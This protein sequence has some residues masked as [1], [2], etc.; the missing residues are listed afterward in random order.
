MPSLFDLPRRDRRELGEAL[1][2]AI[3]ASKRVDLGPVYTQSLAVANYLRGAR[4]FDIMDPFQPDYVLLAVDV[5]RNQPIWEQV[6]GD[7]ALELG[8]QLRMD[9]RPSPSN[10]DTTIRSL[11][12]AAVAR[13]IMSYYFPERR[14]S[15]AHRAFQKYAVEDGCSGLAVSPTWYPGS[16]WGLKLDAIPAEELIFLPSGSR[17]WDKVNCVVW[18][19][20]VTLNWLRAMAAKMKEA[21]DHS[22]SGLPRK[23]SPRYDDLNVV[24]V[25]PG[26]GITESIR[27]DYA[28]DLSGIMNSRTGDL[29]T[30]SDVSD[31]P[32]M[33]PFVEF[34]QCYVTP[35]KA[36]AE[37]IV[38]MAGEFVFLDEEYAEHEMPQIPIGVGRYAD[39]GG[40]YGRSYAYPKIMASILGERFLLSV[41]RNAGAIDAYGM[42]LASTGMGLQHD[43]IERPSDGDFRI[44]EFTPDAGNPTG[45]PIQLTPVALNQIYGTLPQFMLGASQAVFPTSPILRG[46]T[47][48]REDSDVAL[49]RLD[50]LSN[51]Q[52]AAGAITRAT[53]WSQVYAASLEMIR[54]HHRKGDSI[55][56]TYVD[57]S[58]AG[59]LLDTQEIPRSM[60]EI[61]QEEERQAHEAEQFTA[62]GLDPAMGRALQSAGI[63]QGGPQPADRGP[64]R[65]VPMGQFT[66]GP[67]VIPHPDRVSIGVASVMPRDKVAELV[68]LKESRNE[69]LISAMELQ[70]EVYK[71]GLEAPVGGKAVWNAYELAV[72]N[73][74]SAYGNGIEAGPIIVPVAGITQRIGWWVVRT[75]MD[76]ITFA[77]ASET[78]KRKII[79]LLQ[80]YSPV[81]TPQ[82]QPTVDEIAAMEGMRQQA[83]T[84]GMGPQGAPQPGQMALAQSP[85]A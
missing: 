43:Q 5:P 17:S 77:V 48:G 7:V 13:G 36:H 67:N 14:I 34:S 49:Q 80:A 63:L 29:P 59:I 39:V 69:G 24:E 41:A 55:P 82:S 11:R 85:A 84:Q 16:G 8:R 71:R 56:L 52:I 26:H 1:R 23:G 57:D 33:V 58:M 10:E 20:W 73:L 68:G 32:N 47:S 83:Q 38:F 53:A 37:R 28:G 6:V 78:V 45:A 44:G 66:V 9:A 62:R 81:N 25:L 70:I 12:D 21:G 46:E 19:R 61:Q 18:R 22:V 3:D 15:G 65:R 27:G 75:F 42:L 74:L 50:I 2:L 76:G 60:E 79:D 54:N 35:N 72:L 30:T 64:P 40:P 31:A 4:N 51:T